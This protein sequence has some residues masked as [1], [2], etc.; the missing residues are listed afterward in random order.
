[1]KFTVDATAAGSR[2]RAG[3][4]VTAHA[5]IA[6]PVFMPVGTRGSVRTQTPTQVDRLGASII[7]ANTYHLMIHPGVDALVR[8][9]GLRRWI[10]WPGAILTDSGGFQVFSLDD[11]CAISEQGAVFRVGKDGPKLRLS[12]EDAMAAQRAIGS[13]I[14]M[15]LDQCI[16]ATSPLD[17]TR[18]AMELT[19]RWARRSLA[20]RGDTDQALFAIVQGG[21]FPA[22]RR[23]SADVLTSIDGFDGY[24]IGGLA[25]GETRD[26]RQ[27]LTELTAERLPADRPR[28]LMGVGTPIDLL[29]GVHRGIDLFDCILPTAWAQQGIAFTSHGKVDLR[30]GV[31]R[32]AD[33]KLDA[34]CAC[35]ACVRLPRS[36]LHHLF[37]GGEPVGW[38]LLAFHNLA[39]YLRLMGEIRA[40]IRDGSFAAYYA[41]QRAALVAVDL[42]NPP[43]SQPRARIRRAPVRGAFQ[44]RIATQGHASIQHVASGELMHS[45]NQPDDEAHRLYVGQSTRI[46]DALVGAAPLVVWDV[47]LGA[48]HNAMA[49]VRA[50]DGAPAHADVQLVSFERDLDALRLAL[51]HQKAFAHLRHEAPHRLAATGRFARTALTW[52]LVE[53]DF[54]ARFADAPQPDVIWYDPF[55]A[56]VDGPLWSAQ[57]FARLTSFLRGP[58]ELFTYTRSSVIRTAMRSAGFT[59]AKG[60]PSGPKEETTIAHYTR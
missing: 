33:D 9:G 7:L 59:I 23:E 41:R 43:A 44:V 39:F 17:T 8:F 24:A 42:A 58:V 26:Q 20:A 46:A 34:A 48:G 18:A 25:V 57:T 2:A 29:E 30:R 36:Y 54:L 4:L 1:M 37:K 32:L 47:G 27:D 40:A 35:D 5:I 51:E 21:G 3:T 49:L 10:D 6:T 12:P 45:V 52:S 50:L 22:L 16:A 38:Q 56:K 15:V 11:A 13:D 53:G 14:M 28:Y 31:Y 19:H 55:S 60:V